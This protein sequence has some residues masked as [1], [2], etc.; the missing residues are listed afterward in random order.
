MSELGLC[1]ATL[2]ILTVQSGGGGTAGCVLANRLSSEPSVSVLLVER[3]LAHDTWAARVPLLSNP[4]S[5]VPGPFHK[6]SNLA[7]AA[8]GGRAQD[9]FNSAALGGTS[10]VNAMLYTRGLPGEY[11]AWSEAGRHGWSYDELLPLFKKSQRSLVHPPAKYSVEF[12][13]PLCSA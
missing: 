11:N 5:P 2:H 9:L 12:S 8:L 1:C 7:D 10:R 6:Q 4:F 3:G 13:L